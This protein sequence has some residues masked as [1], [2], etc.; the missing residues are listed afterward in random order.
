MPD[1]A[2]PTRLDS[3]PYYSSAFGIGIVAA[4]VMTLALWIAQQAGWTKLD[5]AMTLGTVSGVV[6][7]PSPGAWVQGF[8][9]M[10]ICG[11]L[12]A[13]VYA[14]LF[15][16]QP[17][18]TARAWSG[19]ILGAL[20]AIAGG[21]LLGWTMPY[22]HPAMPNYPLLADPGFMAANYGSQTVAVFVGIHVLY[23]AMVGCWM[24]YSRVDSKY[25]G[26]VKALHDRARQRRGKAATTTAAQ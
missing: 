3:K 14:W 26:W 6:W 25:L 23:G 13:L 2:I 10:L 5:L 24:H 22:L 19:G 18:H 20:H 9:A 16:V 4:A 11:G 12:F 8:I 21:A 15:E 7:G 17:A 1:E